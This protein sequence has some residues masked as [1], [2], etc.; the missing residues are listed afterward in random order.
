[1]NKKSKNEVIRILDSS[2]EGLSEKI[3]NERLIKYGKNILEKD[4]KI[5]FFKKRI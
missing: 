4:K 3:A 5:K 2:Y 1:M